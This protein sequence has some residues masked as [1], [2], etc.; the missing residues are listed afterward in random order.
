MMVYRCLRYQ[1]TEFGKRTRKRYES[2]QIQ[3]RWGQVHNL[4]PRDDLYSNTISGV[5]KDNLLCVI[6]CEDTMTEQQALDMF[7]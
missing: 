1:R 7:F 3:L 4:Q 2:G 5:I 6:E